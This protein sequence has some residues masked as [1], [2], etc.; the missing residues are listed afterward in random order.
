M[1]KILFISIEQTDSLSKRGMLVF[2]MFDAPDLKNIICG[3]QDG[4]EC[5][6]LKV[7]CGMSFQGPVTHLVIWGLSLYAEMFLCL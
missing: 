6:Y 7:N 1:V 2:D 5:S 3:H 4:W